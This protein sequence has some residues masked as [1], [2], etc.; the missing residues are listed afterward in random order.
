MGRRDPGWLLGRSW[1]AR[2]A[3]VVDGMTVRL[4]LLGDSIAHGQGAEAASEN[5]AARLPALLA[6][7]GF[8]VTSRVFA[9]RGARS[10]DLAR[11]VAASVPWQPQLAVVVIGANDLAH[12]VAPAHA[13]HA[14]G[15]AVRDLVAAGAQVVVAPAPDLSVVPHVPTQLRD[16]VRVGSRRL[17]ELQVREVLASGGRVADVDGST[18]ERFASDRSLFSADF[19]HPSG[20]GYAVIAEAFVPELLR[21]LEATTP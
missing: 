5:L 12:R 6:G 18:S 1:A 20:A 14:L 21:A 4:A 19:F 10:N 2:D 15:A 17:R 11:Q 7:H 16:L 9:K 3:W 13:A 8:D